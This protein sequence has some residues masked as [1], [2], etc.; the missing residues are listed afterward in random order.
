VQLDGIGNSA[1][2]KISLDEFKRW[3]SE[4]GGILRPAK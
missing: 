1:V 2:D 3:L 4:A